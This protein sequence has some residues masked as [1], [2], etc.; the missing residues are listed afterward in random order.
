[1]TCVS[2]KPDNPKILVSSSYDMTIKTWDITSGSCLS[3]LSCDSA[4]LS[5]DWH[6]NCIAAGDVDG[7]IYVFDA[8]AGK[9]KSS[10]SGHSDCVRSVSW[11]P[12]VTKLA[13][14]SEDKTV[15]S[16]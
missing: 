14:G 12:E 8:A 11:S 3:T 6:D 9:I 13:S 15:R 5:V 1:M 4:V 2:F 7:K 16:W 10:L